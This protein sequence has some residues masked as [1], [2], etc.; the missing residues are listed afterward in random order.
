MTGVPPEDLPAPVAPRAHQVLVIAGPTASGKTAVA[1]ACAELLG[2][3]IICADSRQVY[4][5]LA[6]ATAKPSPEEVA[7]VP[8]HLLGCVPIS[9]TYTAG[10]FYRDAHG[11]IADI[12]ARGRIPVVAGGTGLYIR[13][14]LNGIFDDD[15]AASQAERERL[16]G[17]LREKGPLLLYQELQRLDPAGAPS[18]PMTNHP[19]LVRALA[20]CRAT[21]RP[22]SEV[23][24]ERM[25]APGIVPFQCG[26]R[27][28]RNI[29]YA[30]IDQRVDSM[31]AAGLVDEVRA[32]LENGADPAWTVMNAV[33]IAEVVAYLSGN[34]TR[35]RMIE[36]IKQH[37]RNFAKR[38][39]TWY[40]KEV[41]MRWYDAAHDAELP[42][43][44]GKIVADF[45]AVCSGARLPGV[46][47]GGGDG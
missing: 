22:Y 27:W 43:L 13:V 38:Q 16:E 1:L 40:R 25:Q 35:E 29:L 9:H 24:R 8:H 33:G 26:I 2:G 11:A 28:D 36:L 19:R 45:R 39:G 46:D 18:V 5:G 32:A 31:I 42:T 6:I 7:R 17:E 34:S 30:R 12:T 15:E 44:A 23:R 47:S 37:T 41:A 20:V 21:G 10:A 4:E 3:E 14:L